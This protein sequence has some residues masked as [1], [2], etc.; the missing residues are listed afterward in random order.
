MG[1]NG[2]ELNIGAPKIRNNFVQT[3]FNFSLLLIKRILLLIFF[4]LFLLSLLL[5]FIAFLYGYYSLLFLNTIAMFLP[6]HLRAS[7]S[8]TITAVIVGRAIT[9]RGAIQKRSHYLS[10]KLIQ[11][12]KQRDLER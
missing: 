1:N 4:V 2:G 12:L 10:Y 6:S 8:I 3:I 11:K 7:R 9:A 5:F